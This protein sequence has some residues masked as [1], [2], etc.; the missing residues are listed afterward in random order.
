MTAST[1]AEP[2]RSHLTRLQL[3]QTA[4]YYI[5]F[6]T[7]GLV[8][9]SLGPTLPGLA[10]QTVSSVAQISY[11]FT[12][13]SLGYLIGSFVGGRFYDRLP[14]H[15][16]MAFVLGIVGLAMFFVPS[17]AWLPLLVGVL[18]TIGL[19]EGA[20]DVGGNTLLVW[21]HREGVGPF[22][23]GLHFF[24]GFGAFLAPIIVAWAIGQTGGI[25]LAYR[26]L[27]L[28]VLPALIWLLR[29][30]SPAHPPH[31]TGEALDDKAVSRNGVLDP[32]LLTIMAFLFLYVGAEISFGG[33]VYTYAVARGLASAS[34]AAYLTSAFWGSL[35]L[36]RLLTIPL[37]ARL[38]PAV[39]LSLSLSGCLV[40]ITIVLAG[41]SSSAAIWA[42]A[43]LMGL[44]MAAVFPVTITLAGTLM[45]I[46]GRV[47]AW[48][49]VGSSAGGMV[50]PWLIGQ[51]FEPI[52][53]EAVML[54]IG[55]DLVL[56]MALFVAV[57]AQARSRRRE[58]AQ[59][60]A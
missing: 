9:A 26:G 11:L 54:V 45:P 22:M 49:F 42:G 4:G 36:G 23:N 24:W 25:A 6:V 16:V 12:A 7:L 56:A 15:R 48:F 8:G 40:A 60:A 37:A 58:L 35:T 29:V 59:A 41:G 21:V 13:R 53:A 44:S 27:G 46:T 20:L 43:I 10:D 30:A 19:A 50:I 57:L 33:W 34:M 32:L 39:L 1:Q 31:V 51:L 47:T 28:L 52:G 38:R 2:G 18:L 5:A 17:V 3:Q 55:V 14:G